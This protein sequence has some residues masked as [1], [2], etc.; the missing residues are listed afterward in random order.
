MGDVRP[1]PFCGEDDQEKLGRSMIEVTCFS[2]SGTANILHWRNRPVEEALLARAEAAEHALDEYRDQHDDQ[3][4][5]IADL[6]QKLGR[7]RRWLRTRDWSK[8]PETK[9]WSK[10]LGDILDG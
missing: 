4:D 8:Y 10:A 2:C 7:V 6:T 9:R 5:E 3:S 1:C